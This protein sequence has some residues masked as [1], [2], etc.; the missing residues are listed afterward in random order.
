MQYSKHVVDE[1]GGLPP[2]FTALQKPFALT[3]PFPQLG[4]ML[5]GARQVP[6]QLKSTPH[7]LQQ[8]GHARQPPR[9]WEH[10]QQAQ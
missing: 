7:V 3:Q 5:E 10:T 6:R 2:G 1:K 9:Q 8:L 4:G